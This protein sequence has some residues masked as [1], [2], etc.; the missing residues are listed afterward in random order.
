MQTPD[1]IILRFSKTAPRGEFV[2]LHT[3][4]TF[5]KRGFK[6]F[7]VTSDI[8]IAPGQD[9]FTGRPLETGT[10]KLNVIPVEFCTA[11]VFR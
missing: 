3:R 7:A 11:G 2:T 4:N 10:G 1:S 6:H 9:V 8:E 5:T